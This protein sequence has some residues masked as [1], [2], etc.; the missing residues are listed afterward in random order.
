MP[1]KQSSRTRPRRKTN[2]NRSGLGA[3]GPVWPSGRNAPEVRFFTFQ[4]SNYQLYHN[5]PVAMA[6]A[7]SLFDNITQGVG[8]GQRVGSRIFAKRLRARFVFNNKTDRPNCSYRVAVT[9]APASTNTDAF[10]ELFSQ[11]GFTGVHAITNSLLLYDTVFPL[12]QGSG[13]ENNMTPNKER[14]FNHT[15]DIPLNHAVVYSTAD[16]KAT[17]ALTVWLVA[18]DAYGTLTTDNIAS[19]AQVTFSIDYTDY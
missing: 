7:V 10:S 15:L 17:T 1:N 5:V 11:G 13:M 4:G 12:N 9:A 14:S 2:G 18:Y 8:L 16:S 3:A 19:V 6:N